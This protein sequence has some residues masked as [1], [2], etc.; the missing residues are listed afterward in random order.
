MLRRKTSAT[1]I[2][3]RV[4]RKKNGV[5][6][7]N[8]PTAML[9]ASRDGLSS[10]WSTDVTCS[11]NRR[12]EKTTCRGLSV[13]PLRGRL[14]LGGGLRDRH[15]HGDLLAVPEDAEGDGLTS[16]RVEDQALEVLQVL[17][18]DVAEL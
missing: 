10:R 1:A 14:A 13:A 12:Q 3:S 8:T 17:D 9:A 15:R 18:G 7:M 4:W 11:R 16:W 6:P 5:V 2:A